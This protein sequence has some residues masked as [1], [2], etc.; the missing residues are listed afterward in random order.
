MVYVHELPDCGGCNC[1]GR[2]NV[3]LLCMLELRAA[4]FHCP[5][6]F[7]QAKCK[8]FT[9]EIIVQSSFMFRSLIPVHRNGVATAAGRA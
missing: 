4:P 3:N 7:L 9:P 8:I 6:I 5:A 2:R 1:N